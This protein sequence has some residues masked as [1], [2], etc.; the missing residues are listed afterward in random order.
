MVLTV[1][2]F[3]SPE[4]TVDVAPQSANLEPVVVPLVNQNPSSAESFVEKRDPEPKKPD[5]VGV[6]SKIGH[7][8]R[9]CY[10]SP[11]QCWLSGQKKPPVAAAT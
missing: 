3:R 7:G 1:P 6:L 2:S 4:A 11:I 10:F 8:Y 9:N 5:F